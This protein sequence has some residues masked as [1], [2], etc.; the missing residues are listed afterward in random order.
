[1]HQD[2]ADVHVY[3]EKISQVE[4]IF[5]VL[6]FILYKMGNLSLVALPANILVLPFIEKLFFFT[7]C[8]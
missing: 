1:M 6:P 2:L 3:D 4:C 5:F 8:F 7:H